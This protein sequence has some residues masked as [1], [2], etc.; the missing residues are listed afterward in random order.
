MNTKKKERVY[1]Y[2]VYALVPVNVR[3]L[4]PSKAAA[5]A[6]ALEALDTTRPLDL[7]TEDDSKAMY[8]DEGSPAT[9]DKAFCGAVVSCSKSR[10]V[11]FVN[12]EA[13]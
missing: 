13:R 11:Q 6:R 5:R 8:I 12:E 7:S 9:L 1:P 10:A 2:M 3:V 4:A